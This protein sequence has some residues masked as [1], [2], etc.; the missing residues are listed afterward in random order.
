M[1]R[2]LT[3]VAGGV[4]GA[5]LTL[6]LPVGAASW[7]ASQNPWFLDDPQ[8]F[9]R[10][11]LLPLALLGAAL[12]LGLSGRLGRRWGVAL[13]LGLAL[14]VGEGLALGRASRA[15]QDLG[16]V[17]TRMLIFG[18]DG[19][20]WDIVHQL[21]MPTLQALTARGASG[22]LRAEPPLFSP[23]LWTTIA[24]GKTP[25]VHG[26]HGFHVQSDHV[27]AAQFWDI[28][29][30]HGL[31]V[32]LYKWLVTWPPRPLAS[33][34]FVVP[35]WLAPEP[36]TWP[37][38]LSFIKEIELS[39]RIKRKKM[40]GARPLWR[41]A[42]AGISQ[43]L[44]WSSLR[45]GALFALS[46][47]IDPSPPP[48]RGAFLQLL[49]VRMDRDVFVHQ[50]HLRRPDLA[51]FT[52]YSTDA[53]GHSHWAY[54]T[55]GGP[56][57][58]AVADAYRQADAVLGEILT[59]VGPDTVV[60]V[61][62]DH[63]MRAIEDADQAHHIAP[64]TERL[65]ARL[66]PVLGQIEVTRVGGRLTL[67]LLDDPAQPG[68]DERKARLDAWIAQTPL[69]S[70]GQPVFRVEAVPGAERAVGL[71][72]VDEEVDDA[73]LASDTVGGEPLSDYVG[74]AEGYTGDHDP[75]GVLVV[76]GGPAQAGASLGVVSQRDVLPTLLGLL[77]I[78]GARDLAGRALF[79]AAGP[80]IETYDALAP[81]R[82]AD[83]VQAE[84][85]EEALRSLGYIE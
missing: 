28:A 81:A 18:V 22:V 36:D 8:S 14:L 74:R 43:G 9:V 44:R 12:G 60:M 15:A 40:E 54:M 30:F 77:D 4:L 19:A 64:R 71:V 48:R 65:Q 83:P 32:G 39:Q 61:L 7:A 72:L 20:T 47:R 66:T 82:N 75:D 42:L 56:Y 29:S 69:G 38:E 70:T 85:N 3:W 58:S 46:E 27:R 52:V 26:I 1:S 2:I 10:L 6:A 53:L 37:D 51:S 80:P 31:S 34:G 63:G 84:V 76:A 33:G 50:L 16:P 13:A 59:H 25:E 23:L 11:L 67:T 35:G 24:T 62:S 21:D 49:R 78:P 73:Q 17:P 45:D 68:L 79:G 5:A 57:Q 41:L 55:G